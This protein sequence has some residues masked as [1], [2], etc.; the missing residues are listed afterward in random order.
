MRLIPHRRISIFSV[1]KCSNTYIYYCGFKVH[2][3]KVD[4]VKELVPIWKFQ[5]VF[6]RNYE[7]RRRKVNGEENE[8]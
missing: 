1:V 6:T 7:K 5:P 2:M 4:C 8:I 3:V